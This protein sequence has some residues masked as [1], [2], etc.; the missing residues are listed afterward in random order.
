MT[1][2][3]KRTVKSVV[4]DGII[5]KE[6]RELLNKVAKEEGVSQTD[7]DVYVTEKLKK[8]KIKLEKGGNWFSKNGAAVI[9]AVTS[10]AGVAI[11]AIYKVKK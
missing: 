6:E 1:R 8:R 11:T 7:A 5:T 9:T 3:F 10:F 2:R 4:L